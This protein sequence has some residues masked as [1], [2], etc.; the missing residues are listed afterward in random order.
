[1]KRIW[2]L[3]AHLMTAAATWAACSAGGLSGH[4]QILVVLS[5]AIESLYKLAAPTSK[6]R[7]EPMENEFDVPL[8]VD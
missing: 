4:Q 3:F 8:Y 7:P 2:G 5:L 1:M 6:F